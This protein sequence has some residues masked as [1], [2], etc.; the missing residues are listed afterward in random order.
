[1]PLSTYEALPFLFESRIDN[2]GKHTFCEACAWIII[3][4]PLQNKL[5]EIG[6]PRE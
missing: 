1:M 5:S 3:P 2:T 6:C 4:S